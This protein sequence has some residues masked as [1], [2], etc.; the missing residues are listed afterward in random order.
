MEQRRL[1]PRTATLRAGNQGAFDR[2]ATAAAIDQMFDVSG[3]EFIDEPADFGSKAG[4]LRGVFEVRYWF[5]F[6]TAAAA[7]ARG[8]AASGGIYRDDSLDEFDFSFG[9]KQ[10]ITSSKISGPLKDL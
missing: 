7:A 5:W 8:Q 3:D 9:I 6:D 4:G 1:S 10:P 2:T